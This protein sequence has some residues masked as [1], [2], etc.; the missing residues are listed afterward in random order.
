MCSTDKKI[1]LLVDRREKDGKKCKTNFL[2]IIDAMLGKFVELP[3][4]ATEIEE[5]DQ[6]TDREGSTSTHPCRTGAWT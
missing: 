1:R 2:C 4:Q 6:L 3:I 5:A